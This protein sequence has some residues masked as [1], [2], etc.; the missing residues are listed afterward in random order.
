MSDEAEQGAALF[1]E[2]V[3]DRLRAARVKAGLDL[4]DVATRTRVPLRHLVAIEGGDYSALP[5][6]TYSVGFVKS[7]ARAVGEDEHEL[8]K[9]LRDELGQE[10]ALERTRPVDLDD[11]DPGPVPSSRLAWIAGL[12][13]LIVAGGYAAIRSYQQE[14]PEVVAP[15]V[16]DAGEDTGAAPANAAAPAAAPNPKGNVL[17]LARDAV[18]LRVYDANDKVL[19][20]KE[21]ARG[22]SWAVPADANNPMIRT[23][24]A[25]L[26]QVTVDG[27]EVAPLGPPERT[28]KDVGLSAGALA[29][30]APAAVAS[31]A[32][33]QPSAAASAAAAATPANQSQ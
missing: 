10:T 19:F 20:E 5:S 7:Y 31:P 14:V 22:E 11:D 18:W 8:A 33:A 3:G 1:P 30:R 29:A 27:K 2:R 9:A 32:T 24:R 26:I 21:M 13:F 23:G 12:I 15:A 6:I 4:S 16:E 25:D 17:L 28:I